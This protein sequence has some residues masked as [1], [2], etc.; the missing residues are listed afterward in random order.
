MDDVLEIEFNPKLFNPLFWHIKE[1]LRD[2]K[3]RYIY[4]EGGSSASKTDTICTAISID[5]LEHDYSTM[6][7][8]RQLVDIRDSV[9]PSF[10]DVIKRHE[11]DTFY[12]AQLNIIRLNT[13]DGKHRIR[14]KGLD[15]EEN[16]KGI[17]RYKVIYNNEW[18][19]FEERHWEQQRK[20]LRGEPNQKFICDWNPISS[21]LWQYKN[22]LDLDTWIDQPL[23]VK[24]IKYS[25]LNSEFAFK[26]KN[27]AGD[28]I[29]IKVTFRD[30]YWIVGHPSGKGGF[31]DVHTLKDYEWDRVHKP[32]LYRVY[33][34]GERGILRTGGEFWKQFDELKHVRP[35]QIEESTLHVSLDENVSPYVTT[36]IW[37]LIGKN[38]R[39]V[40][41]IPC[42]EPDNNAPKAAR[43]LV[44][45]LRKINYQDVVY[46]YGDPSSSKRSTVDENNR[47]FYDKYIGVLKNEGYTVVSRVGKSHPQVA[48]SGVFVNDI[49]E[50]LIDGYSITIADTCKVSIDD[51]N[52]VKEAQD[53][54]ML[55]TEVEDKV[56]KQKYQPYG[57][58]SDAKRYFITKILEQQFIKYKQKT[59][60]TGSI[61][62]DQF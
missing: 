30:N 49:Y 60:K 3:I 14:F 18:N 23:S 61:A 5:M 9:Y 19:Q 57:H 10:E 32:N 2:P 27:K 39:Q 48:L 22:W 6:V 45:W 38:L 40:H 53:G 58:F 36:S 54:T 21:N 52:M 62:V 15:K 37:Q 31:K 41:E 59:K 11:L 51:Y 25:S 46:V 20:R 17:Q 44:E 50:G 28:A 13:G 43:K 16:I 34:N 12:E 7:F 42:K 29:W 35:L 8:R 24:G 26:R 33:A 56:T 4:V 1:A 47:S 55:K